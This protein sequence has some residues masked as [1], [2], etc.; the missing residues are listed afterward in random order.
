MDQDKTKEQLVSELQ[1]LRRQVTD[2]ETSAIDNEKA[3]KV[4][5][6]SEEKWRS[7]VE[8]SPD[9]NTW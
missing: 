9:K 3:E 8:N 5:R 2:L 4:L 6:E 7:F 1:E